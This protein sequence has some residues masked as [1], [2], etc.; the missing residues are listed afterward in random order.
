MSQQVHHSPAGEGRELFTVDSTATV[1]VGAE[2]T[3][4][5]YELFEID[6][7]RGSFVPP[8]RH[9]WPESYYVLHGRMSVQ[10][11]SKRY[12]MGPGE[13]I[14]V[15]T[16]AAHTIE[17]TSKAVKFLAFSLTDGTGRLFADLD[18]NVPAGRPMAEVAPLITEI[19]ERNRT[20]FLSRPA[21]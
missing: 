17:V 9:P 15:P 5:A 4:G 11:G 14:T 18:A 16:G 21:Q 2:H 19:A 8:H 13:S 12:D 20:T 7:E 1:K 3:D 6:G 10:V